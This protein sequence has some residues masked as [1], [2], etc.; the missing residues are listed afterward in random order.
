MKAL[1]F[2][3]TRS[4]L[5]AR[6]ALIVALLLTLGC[7]CQTS[8][9]T[10]TPPT[11]VAPATPRAP[12]STR[13][14]RPTAPPAPSPAATDMGALG[15]LACI[16]GDPFAAIRQE[17][18]FAYLEALTA[19][20]PYS[21][22]RNSGTEGEAEALDYVA[23]Q[24]Q[25]FA[26]LENM[27]LE[28]ERQQFNV[29]M[30]TELW[31]T[32]LWLTVG[33]AEVEVPADG[34]RGPRDDIPQ[35][36][37]F[38]SDGVLNDSDRNP[39]TAQGETALLRSTEDLD[40]LDDTALRGKIAFLDYALIDRALMPSARG[41]GRVEQ[42]LA[43]GPAALVLVTQFSDVQGE[44]HGFAVADNS[45]LN[46]AETKP[47]VPVLYVRLE[48]LAPAGVADWDDLAQLEAARLTWDADVFQ[49][50][51]SG[52]VI[53]H[54]PGVDASR[55]V[56]LGAHI[57]S[58]N[59]PGAMDDGSGSVILLEIARVLNATCTQPPLDL[60][61]VWFGSEEIGL[62]GGAHFVLT[63]QEL[64]DRAVGMLQIDDLTNPV[65]GFD[66]TVDL[67]GW[68]YARFGDR[69]MA[70]LEAIQAT[71][72]QRGLETVVQ[73]FPYAYSDNSTFTGFDVPN[74]DLIYQ[75]AEAMEA[76]GSFH[77]AAHIHDPYDTVE[78]ARE[79]GDVLE[80]MAHVALGAALDAGA[81]EYRITPATDRRAVFVASHTESS[82]MTPASFSD[83]GMA[84]SWA[85]FDVDLIPYGQPIAPDDLA[86]AALVVVLPPHDHPNA[87]D[88]AD[89]VAAYDTAWEPAE[90]EAL[91]AYVEEGGFLVLA[92]SAARIRFGTPYDENEDWA[93]LN[94]LAERFGVTYE[95]GALA[96]GS[97]RVRSAHPLMAGVTRLAGLDNNG[98]PLALADGE[99]LAG[100]SSRPAVGL[101]SFGA[102]EVLALADIGFL[103]ITDA[104]DNLR[105]WQNLAEYARER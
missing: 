12:A 2:F 17:T 88:A 3:S 69:Q 65:E 81:A 59:V 11:P 67:V 34:L 49:P 51:A 55:A 30:T 23:A 36:L 32:R 64:L 63:H 10:P 90:V 21:G 39:A 8:T 45:V 15:D 79:V 62:Y 103:S 33:G 92:N 9:L 98:V 52:N 102:G 74:A 61:L 47:A 31:E 6:A 60:Y 48:D 43:A 57:D 105:F 93:D 19:I 25:A 87:E 40:A 70:W 89:G 72:A 4:P 44:S 86:D 66:P 13:T 5:T 91:A 83:V 22:W 26:F 80:Q 53:V 14:P 20:Q 38:D 73:D 50:G 75:E 95:T 18:M 42:V 84:L 68:S 76:T 56:I 85:G 35:A 24:M 54:I 41:T 28:V 82:H 27:G 37:R 77:N 97:V 58:P 7:F 94:A 96:T 71:A 99:V 78:L 104:A 46:F 100:T 16:P 29:F 101:V 1:A